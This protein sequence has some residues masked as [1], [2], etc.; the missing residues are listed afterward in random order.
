MRYAAHETLAAPARPS[1]QLW[2]LALGVALTAACFVVV[3]Y[4]YFNILAG[5]V[6]PGDWPDFAA[7]IDAGSTPRGMFAVLGVFGL[8]TLTLALVM[9]QLHDRSLHSL[10]GPVNRAARDFLRVSV[11]LL[12]LATLLWLLPEPAAM[13]PQPGLPVL[14]WLALLPLALPLVFIQISAEELAFRGYLQSQLAARFS[15]P[16]IWMAGPAVLFGLLHY[17]PATA[18]DNASAIA[19]TAFVFGLAAADLTA[20]AGTLGPAL[21]LHFAN[22]IGALLITAPQGLNDGLA[23]QRFPFAIDDLAA[24][25]TWLPHDLL[26]LLCAWLAA[27]LAI[28]R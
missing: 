9:N 7:E 26:T 16:L 22:N 12:A 13:A 27:R 2:R 8:M 18:G 10:L 15:N 28:R 19:L 23:L 24:R 11:A 3:S 14:R 25:A 20:R 1:A 21:A 4:S 5:L 6:A 17:D